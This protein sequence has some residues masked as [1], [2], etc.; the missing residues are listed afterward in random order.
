MKKRGGGKRRVREKEE[1]KEKWRGSW[2]K[3]RSSFVL[4]KI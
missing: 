2:G 1:K 4:R 3:G